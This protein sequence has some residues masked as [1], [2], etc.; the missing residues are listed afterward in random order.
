MQR[1]LLLTVS[2]IHLLSTPFVTSLLVPL[3]T[4]IGFS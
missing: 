3:C 4:I 2:T 1:P